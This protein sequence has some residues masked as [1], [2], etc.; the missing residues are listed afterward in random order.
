MNR[1]H[2]HFALEIREKVCEG[3]AAIRTDRKH[4]ALAK[5][6]EIDG[7][8]IRQIVEHELSH[9]TCQNHCPSPR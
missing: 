3:I 7:M 8:L 4:L 1:I 6:L 9:E 2:Q 5:L